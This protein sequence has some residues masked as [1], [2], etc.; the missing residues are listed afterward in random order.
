VNLVPCFN[1]IL[2]TFED[3]LSLSEALDGFVFEGR[4]ADTVLDAEF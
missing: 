4:L 1:L 3:L 2:I